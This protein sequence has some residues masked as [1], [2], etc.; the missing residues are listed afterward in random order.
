M[1]PASFKHLFDEARRDPDFY[2]ELAILEFTEELYR[3]MQEKEVS[4][5]ELGRRISSSQAYV[6]RV[7]NGGANFTLATMTKLGAALG[8][9]L[10]MHLAPAGSVT[11]WRDVVTEDH[12]TREVSSGVFTAAGDT[13]ATSSPGSRA[14]EHFV[15]PLTPAASAQATP[16]AEGGRRAGDGGPGK[17]RPCDRPTQG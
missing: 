6:S 13:V 16:A 17:T 3:I 7:L 9:E 14:A 5:T 11:V 10:R 2:K 12:G 1:S 4:H 15:A 8:M